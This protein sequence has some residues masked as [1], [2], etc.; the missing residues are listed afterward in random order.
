LFHKHSI[1]KFGSYGDN[2]AVSVYRIFLF[3]LTTTVSITIIGL[4]ICKLICHQRTE[5]ARSSLPSPLLTEMLKAPAQSKACNT[6]QSTV[7]DSLIFSLS[8]LCV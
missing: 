4:F 1:N 2:I 5:Y 6:V 8:S 7:L 3:V